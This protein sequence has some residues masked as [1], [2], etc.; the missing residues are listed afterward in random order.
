[1]KLDSYE[2][3]TARLQS[4]CVNSR[5]QLGYKMRGGLVA[6]GDVATQVPISRGDGGVSATLQ[7]DLE[8]EPS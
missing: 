7:G 6:D 8:G 3:H 5:P 1:M 2:C 4:D